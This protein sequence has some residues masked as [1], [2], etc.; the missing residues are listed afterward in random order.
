M[1]KATELI[2]VS[3]TQVSPG[4][5]PGKKLAPFAWDLLSCVLRR[6]NQPKSPKVLIDDPANTS[7]VHVGFHQGIHQLVE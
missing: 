2:A 3:V 1:E 4:C 5:I 7:I 6:S